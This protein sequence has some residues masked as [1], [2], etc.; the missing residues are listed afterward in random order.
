MNKY[1]AKQI[2]SKHIAPRPI[3]SEWIGA[4]VSTPMGNGTVVEAFHNVNNGV[5]LKV[6]RPNG[7]G[8]TF[9]H[10]VTVI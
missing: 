2:M 3:A 9:A 4:H 5:T 6:N 7:S 1:Q 10:L 8:Y